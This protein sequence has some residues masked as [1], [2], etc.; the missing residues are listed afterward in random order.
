MLQE[1]AWS[2]LSI[3]A[4][5]K[6]H[7]FFWDMVNAPFLKNDDIPEFNSF[8]S[9]KVWT[10]HFFAMF[11]QNSEISGLVGCVE[12]STWDHLPLDITLY[13]VIQA[14]HDRTSGGAPEPNGVPVDDFNAAKE[15]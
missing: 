9:C 8:I 12:R 15:L 11:A 7:K 13:E 3:A 2:K 1:E 4:D 6:D 10:A 14:L 5:I